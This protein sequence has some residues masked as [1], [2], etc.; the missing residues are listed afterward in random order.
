LGLSCVGILVRSAYRTVELGE[1]F[2]GHLS[3]TE[4]YFYALDTL[5]L[6]IACVVYVVVWPGRVIK[7][8]PVKA[9]DVPLAV[10]EAGEGERK[11]G[12]LTASPSR[13]G[14]SPEKKV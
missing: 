6:F 3:T 1:G 2:N 12:S 4:S 9:S 5:P 8:V 14:E 13:E 10:V 7:A 11:S